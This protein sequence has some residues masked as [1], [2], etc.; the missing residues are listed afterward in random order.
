MFPLEETDWRVLL[1]SIQQGKC[2]LL[3]GPGV[4]VD[5]ADPQGDPLPVQLAQRLAGELRNAGKGDQL[6]A[7]GDLAHVAQTYKRAMRQHRAGLELAMEDFYSPY[8]TR[9]RSYISIWPRCL[10]HSASARLRN[11]SS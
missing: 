2:V 3:L 8:R 5:P 11:G 9:P 6:L 7:V 1:K 10:S 4:A